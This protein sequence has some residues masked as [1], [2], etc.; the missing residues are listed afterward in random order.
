MLSK[1]IYYLNYN[2]FLILTNNFKLKVIKS[3]YLSLII[4]KA[5]PTKQ[6]FFPLVK[7]FIHL[8]I[9]KYNK[10]YITQL[11]ATSTALLKLIK[12]NTLMLSVKHFWYKYSEYLT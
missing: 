4:L 9:F 7:N 1:Y 2:I 5:T 12:N 3:S 6:N 8:R 11:D 10:I